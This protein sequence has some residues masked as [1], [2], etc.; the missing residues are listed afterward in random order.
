LERGS[1]NERT[2]RRNETLNERRKFVNE[3]RQALVVAQDHGE[4]VLPL[5]KK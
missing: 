3:P 5:N 1:E 2:K 4:L